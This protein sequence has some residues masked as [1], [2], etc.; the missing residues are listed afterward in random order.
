MTET[1]N[2]PAPTFR[3]TK[4]E[5]LYEVVVDGETVGLVRKTRVTTHVYAN[6]GRASYTC[7]STERTE[8]VAVDN[9][10]RY[11]NGFRTRTLA[12]AAVIRD[13]AA[14]AAR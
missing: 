6:G 4:H 7:G 12:A 13:A 10:T 14:K 3:K 2:T 11:R 5:G 9:S 1:R 8:W